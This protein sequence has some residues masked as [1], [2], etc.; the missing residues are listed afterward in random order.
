MIV[1][2]HDIVKSQL[3][4]ALCMIEQYRKNCSNVEAWLSLIQRRTRDC[5]ITYAQ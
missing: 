5:N 3:T 4:T 2:L 1:T